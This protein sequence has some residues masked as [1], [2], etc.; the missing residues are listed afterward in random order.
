MNIDRIKRDVINPA[1]VY[2]AD[3]S[4]AKNF[5]IST[6]YH[7]IIKNLC[8]VRPECNCKAQVVG[9]AEYCPNRS[10]TFELL[11]FVFSPSV[12]RITYIL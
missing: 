6:G 8:V 9:E 3:Q 2:G 5:H 7:E 1:R 12:I 11:T 4:R 10:I